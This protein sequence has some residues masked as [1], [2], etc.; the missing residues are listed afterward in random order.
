MRKTTLL[1]I[2]IVL[3]SFGVSVY[4]YPQLPKKVASHWN[5]AGEVDD[6]MEKTLGTFLMPVIGV[7][8]AVLFLLIPKID[9]LKKNIEEFRRYYDGFIILMMLFLFYIHILVILWNM[10]IRYNMN[11]V[12]APAFAVLFYYCGILIENSKRNWFIGIRTPWTLSDEEVWKKTHDQ[13]GKLFKAAGIIAL[14]GVFAPDYSIYFV[15][16][17]AILVSGYTIVYSYVEYSK[18]R[19]KG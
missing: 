7:I 4:V 3:L 13:G 9:P 12:L 8:M 11:Q 19:R 14:L 15:L 1:L 16:V 17:P 2:V 6:Y 18:K 5:A 10:N